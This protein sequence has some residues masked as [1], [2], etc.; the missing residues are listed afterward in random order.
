[1]LTSIQVETFRGVDQLKV[2][3]LSHIKSVNPKNRLTPLAITEARILGVLNN[4]RR[5]ANVLG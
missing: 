5:L 4:A 1:M 2:G 3:G